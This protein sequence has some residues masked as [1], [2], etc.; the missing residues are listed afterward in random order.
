VSYETEPAIGSWNSRAVFVADDADGAG[1]FAALS[2][3]LAGGVSASRTVERLYFTAPSALTETRQAILS[4]WTAG[5]S[6]MV[7]TGH[8]TLRQW[9]A[10]RLFH[11]DDAGALA[12]GGRLPIVLQLTCFTGSFHDAGGTTL[13][14][15]LLRRA[16]G[17]AVGVWGPTGLGVATGHDELARAFLQQVYQDG[18]PVVGPALLAGK[19]AVA[20]LYPDLVDTFTWLGDPATSIRLQVVPDVPVYLPL[21]RR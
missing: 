16:G 9:A 20:G 6:V 15:T 21:I 1:D 11:R 18:Q 17:G 8:A 5:A 3:S 7:Y 4:S 13:D 2:D 19:L 12:N 14:E 10:E